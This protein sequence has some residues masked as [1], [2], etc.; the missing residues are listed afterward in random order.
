MIELLYPYALLLMLLPPAFYYFLPPIKGMHGD[1]LRIPF[2]ADLKRISYK[3]GEIWNFSSDNHHFSMKFWLLYLLWGLLCLSAA[4]PIMLGEPQRLPNEG[5]DIMLVLDISTSMLEPDFSYHGRSATRLSAVKNVVY[6]FAKK[7]ISDRIGLIL[8]GTRAYLQSPLTYDKA[9][10]KDILFSMQAGMAGDSTSIG[11]AL[12]L[13]L[14]NMHQSQQ[15]DKQVIIL[16]TDGE[17]HDGSLS[18][19]QAIKMAEEENIKIYTIGVGS[20]NLFFKMLS[21]VGLQG[22]DEQELKVLAQ[23]TRGQYF[24]AASTEDLNKIYQLIDQLEP[25]D[26]EERFIQA[27]TELYYIPLL[28]AWILGCLVIFRWRR[29]SK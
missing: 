29:K 23:K 6:D 25:S 5:R 4:R 26:N 21:A 11:D 10:I 3:N 7:R 8:F 24:R 12:A 2:L 16:L 28:L 14:K 9:A 19:A 20:P 27:S 15:P 17:N 1:A 22:L 13:A 18:M